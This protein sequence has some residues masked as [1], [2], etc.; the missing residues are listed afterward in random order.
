MRMKA[1]LA[2]DSTGPYGSLRG[3][4]G[5][6]KTTFGASAANPAENQLSLRVND[7]F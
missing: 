1:R 4:P 5:K 2:L 7:G 3:T 6:A